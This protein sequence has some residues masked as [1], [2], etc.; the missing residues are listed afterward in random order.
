MGFWSWLFGKKDKTKKDK[1]QIKQTKVMKRTVQELLNFTDI[2][3]D[4]IV[5]T[6]KGFSKLYLLEDANF[7][8]EPEEKQEN[9]LVNY[10]KFINRFPDNVETSVIIV[11]K[12]NSNDTLAD[13]YHIK[14]QG[15]GYD[16]FREDYNKIIDEKIADGHN[17]ISKVKYIMLNCRCKSLRE[18]VEVFTAADIALQ[19]SIK[20][21]NKVGVKQLDAIERL[22]LMHDILNG[23]E[24]VP[25]EKEYDRFFTVTNDTEG[26]ERK[27]LNKKEMRRKGMSIKDIIAPQ[28]VAKERS[29]LFLGEGRYCKGFAYRN[30]PLSLDTSFLTNSTNLPYEMVTV[31]QFKT[32]P[33]KA[34]LR[35]IKIMNTSVKA[36]VAK[37]QKRLQQSGLS[38]DLMNE[39]LKAAYEETQ[40]LRDDVVRKGKKLLYATMV[41]TM[42]AKSEEEM[43]LIEAQFRSKCEDF[44]VTPNYLYGQQTEAL[45]TA[46]CVGTSPIKIDR[47]LTTDDACALFPFNIQE[48]QD[49]KGHFYGINAIS[50][51]MIMYDRKRSRLGN[52]LIF[53]Q[54]GSG[55]SFITKGEIIPNL[56]DG[57][58]DMVI[59]DPENEYRIIAEKFNGTVIDLEMNSNYHINPC[60]MSMEWSDARAAPLTEKSDYMVS[61]VESILGQ[62]RSCNPY[63][64]NVI[65]R[66]CN[67][68]YEPYQNEM[69][70]RY[71]NGDKRDID[72][73]IMPTLKDFYQALLDDQSPEGNKV[74]MAIEPYCVGNYALFAH[75]TNIQTSGRLTVFNL[76]YLPEKMKEMA[77][78]VCLANI[79]TR[80]VK[81]KEENDKNHS[82]K[83][84]WVYLD[85]FHLFFQTESSAT[86][87]MTYFKRVRKY[88]GIMTGITQDVA[89]LLKSQQGTAMF[90]NTGF[91]IFLNQS[92]IGRSQLQNLYQISDSLLDYI[93]D[94]PSGVG[95][96]YNNSVLIPIDYKLPNTS[97]LYKIMST[98]PNDEFNTKKR[99]AEILAEREKREQALYDMEQQGDEDED[100]SEIENGVN[101]DLDDFFDQY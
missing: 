87:I 62:G 73:T 12:R 75:R 19:E 74:A 21:I 44:T 52:G 25:F 15:D 63:E 60:D 49:R 18:A 53:G 34:A 3:E 41:V 50:K 61:L 51:N 29:H 5:T 42:F 58:D 45:N 71:K 90:N 65:H 28:V 93:K 98:N 33:R 82:G 36:D 23:V 37:E 76:L 30:L 43:K 83:S 77:M 56:L 67:K 17:D 72:T 48:L 64:V 10:T 79:W 7:V 92:P 39:D 46:I 97:E 2:E 26:N 27:V 35:A 88:G 6:N 20:A 57:N 96:I 81:N 94:K 1:K 8:T 13:A 47:M 70:K 9:L 95:L 16:I 101:D 86:T 4:G 40:N 22:K 100:E 80:I 55:K 99:D 78:K 59:L 66:A 32:V 24:G 38:G 91:F 54:S 85:E 68:M 14:E 31:I 11:N 89:D 69:R 84:I